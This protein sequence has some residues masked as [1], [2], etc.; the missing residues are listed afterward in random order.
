MGGDREEFV[1]KLNRLLSLVVQA[2]IVDC[3]CTA[4][5]QLDEKRKVTLRVRST[6]LRRHERQRAQDFP[7]RFH[8]YTHERTEAERSQNP[9]VLSVASVFGQEVISDVRQ[10]FG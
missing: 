3:D 8:R 4:S 7:P 2:S 5:R 6:G 9:G 10:I 1:A